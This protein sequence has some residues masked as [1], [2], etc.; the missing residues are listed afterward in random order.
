MNPICPHSIFITTKRQIF[1]LI[2]RVS[3]HSLS[4]FKCE[5]LFTAGCKAIIAFFMIILSLLH[6]MLAL[7]WN[8]LLIV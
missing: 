8:N 1:N 7:I 6:M 5:T 3:L 4:R 2:G